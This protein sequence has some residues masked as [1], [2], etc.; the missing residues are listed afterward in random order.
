MLPSHVASSPEDHGSP[1]GATLA[2]GENK[3]GS[4]YL[5]EAIAA[6]LPHRLDGVAK[7]PPVSLGK[8]STV[9]VHR[10]LSTNRDTVSALEAT[11]PSPCLRPW[12]RRT[13]E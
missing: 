5:V 10:K 6:N 11:H 3:L 1:V 7:P 2:G 12:Q 13:P 8:K 4:V 9:G